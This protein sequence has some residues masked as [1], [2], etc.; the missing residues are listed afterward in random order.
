MI[1][2]ILT[3]DCSL[4]EKFFHFFHFIFSSLLCGCEIFALGSIVRR[5]QQAS[6]DCLTAVNNIC[7]VNVMVQIDCRSIHQ[8]SFR[9]LFRKEVCSE[10][11]VA[12]NLGEFVGG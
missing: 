11:P 5:V 4:R 12:R 6:H 3:I 10:R 8:D 2:I 7:L 9:E 1:L